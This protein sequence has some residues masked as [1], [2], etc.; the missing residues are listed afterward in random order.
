MPGEVGCSAVLGF[1]SRSQIPRAFPSC[2]RH[3]GPVPTCSDPGTPRH[4]ALLLP[5]LQNQGMASPS[6]SI[7]C[8]GPA[9]PMPRTERRHGRAW[10]VCPEF[11]GAP[12]TK[13]A[14]LRSALGPEAAGAQSRFGA[15]A[16][17]GAGLQARNRGVIPLLH[18][19]RRPTPSLQRVPGRPTSI[20]LHASQDRPGPNL[21]L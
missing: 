14:G 19:L 18:D 13:P 9:C 20:R 15:G 11:H 4:L 10:R 5:S 21:P 6:A 3:T 17:G 8:P 2:L 12:K 16:P 7:R 1:L